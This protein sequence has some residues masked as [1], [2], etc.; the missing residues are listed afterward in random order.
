MSIP[1]LFWLSPGER[2]NA[3]T[4]VAPE[5]LIGRRADSD[6]VLLNEHVSRHHAKLMRTSEGYVLV[7]LGSTN[8]TFVND[9]RIRTQLLKHGDKVSVGD[10]D[11][12][13]FANR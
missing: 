3:F 5:I 7:D 9:N 2:E 8:G 6:V 4:L 11:L 10:V 1:Q 12:H 13:Y